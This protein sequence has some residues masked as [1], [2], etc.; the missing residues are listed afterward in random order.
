MAAA[1]NF[2]MTVKMLDAADNSLA[3]FHPRTGTQRNRI[4]LFAG[5]NCHVRLMC[6]APRSTPVDEGFKLPGDIC[7]I[8]R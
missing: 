4:S 6:I 1:L 5:K 2:Q 7:P 3:F 8:R